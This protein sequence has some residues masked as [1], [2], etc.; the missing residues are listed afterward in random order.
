MRQ[1]HTIQQQHQLTQHRITQKQ[2]QHQQQQ[3][4]RHWQHTSSN[5]IKQQQQRLQQ[6]LQ[7]LNL[8]A[9]FVTNVN[10]NAVAVSPSQVLQ[11]HVAVL[12]GLMRGER[13]GPK[14]ASPDLRAAALRIRLNA[15]TAAG[16]TSLVPP[17]SPD[18]KGSCGPCCVLFAVF[19]AG[20]V[21]GALSAIAAD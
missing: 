10:G 9:P 4:Q 6:Q 18:P 3:Q 19:A 7:Q 17:D 2:Q 21:I 13:Q 15:R 5:H 8:N 20:W 11:C 12:H 16:L 1:Q 14:E